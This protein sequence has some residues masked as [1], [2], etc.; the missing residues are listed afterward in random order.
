MSEDETQTTVDPERLFVIMSHDVAKAGPVPGGVI[1][2]GLQVVSELWLEKCMI[3][4]SFIAL[5]SYPLGQVIREP[6]TSL[7]GSTINVSGFDVIE[8]VHIVKI[9]TL[10]GG[11][12]A[13]VLSSAV[14]MLI[15]RDAFGRKEKLEL[16]QHLGIPVVSEDWL[17]STMRSQSK[18]NIKDYL[19]Q[20]LRARGANVETSL[21]SKAPPKQHPEVGTTSLKRRIGDRPTH[22]QGE[23]VENPTTTAPKRPSTAVLIRQEPPEVTNGPEIQDLSEHGRGSEGSETQAESRL[24]R[25]RPLRE[26]SPTSARRNFRAVEPAKAAPRSLDGASGMG[27]P[28]SKE[29]PTA[30][31]DHAGK[32]IDV[33]AINGAI[34]DMLDARSKKKAGSSRVTDEPKKKSRLVGRALSNLSNSSS[35]SNVRHSRASSIDSINTDGRGSEVPAIQSGEGQSGESTAAAGR[36][37]FSFT[38]RAKTT[39]GGLSSA[40]LGMDDP[41]IARAACFQAEQ[42]AA[43][44]MTQLGYEDPEEAILLRE[45][46]AA[47][48]KKRSKKEGVEEQGG[49]H[50]DDPKP[51]ATKQK[52]SDRKIRDDDILARADAGWGAGRRT[53]HKQRSPQ[54]MQEF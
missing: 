35:K 7:K 44:R 19:L 23:A 12:Y 9:V 48:R 41:D 43:P 11:T 8:N 50:D 3:A 39:L 28:D 17:W 26:V 14:S 51:P 30:W 47:S 36:S 4:K 33:E 38:G 52:P 18:T 29:N 49:S 1:L 34:R 40:A 13:K 20:P 6:R 2:D 22:R 16:A 42:E 24:Q 25:M 54:G 32:T 37:S 45:K 5:Q 15:C 31:T 53:R 27:E 21:Q 10:L 46:L